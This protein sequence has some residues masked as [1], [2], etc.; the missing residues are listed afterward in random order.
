MWY[1]ETGAVG[2]GLLVLLLVSHAVY[3]WTRAKSLP[4]HRE[5]FR[6]VALVTAVTVINLWYNCTIR[7]EAAYMT[8]FVLSIS[9]IAAKEGA[10]VSR[11]RRGAPGSSTRTR[12]VARGASSAPAGRTTATAGGQPSITQTFKS[13]TIGSFFRFFD[14]LERT[15]AEEPE[16]FRDEC[17]LRAARRVV[18]YSRALIGMV[19][20]S[21]SGEA[22][23][24]RYAREVCGGEALARACGGYPFWRLPAG[25]AA[26][27]LC[28]RFRLAGAALL[29]ARMRARTR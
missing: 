27:F 12:F 18:D 4:R 9:C 29:L 26:F 19:E 16:R 7:T 17:R 6:F 23:K 13:T 24:R 2:F 5:S 22:E 10:G 3:S 21:S 8:F 1:I 25:Q 14:L 11:L 28:L 15:A 20:G